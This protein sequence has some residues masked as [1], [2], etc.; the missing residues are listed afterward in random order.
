MI[1][2]VLNECICIETKEWEIQELKRKAGNLEN[3]Q[4]VLARESRDAENRLFQVQEENSLLRG[5]NSSL[6]TQLEQRDRDIEWGKSQL[7]LSQRREREKQTRIDELTCQLAALQ[8]ENNRNKD[9]IK[10]LKGELGQSQEE[11]L[12]QK[13]GMKLEK[14]ETLAQ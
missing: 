2:E 10:D 5:T 7:A 8:T 9:K 14:L 12:N 11:Y 13:I 4:L 1:S 3:N 6:Q